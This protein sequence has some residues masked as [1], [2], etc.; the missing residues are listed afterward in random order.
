[1]SLVAELEPLHPCPPA[2]AMLRPEFFARPSDLVAEALIGKVLWR[3]GVGGGRLTEVEAY[4]PEGDPASHAARG[5][6]ARNAAMFGP[7]GSIYVFLSY[8]VH[9]LLNIVCDCEGVGAAVLIR[10]FEPM[11]EMCPSLPVGPGRAARA[12]EID[13]G[14]NGRYLGGNSGLAVFDDG[15]RPEVAIS[16]RIGISQGNL[17]PLRFCA[18]GSRFV[19]GTRRQRKEDQA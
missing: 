6:T 16:T 9:W 14:L 19:S 15:T 5:P 2:A 18:A 12:L 17:L 10:A 4:L 1:M 7:A 11:C 3:A 8:G 13:A